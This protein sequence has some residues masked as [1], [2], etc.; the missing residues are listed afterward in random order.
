MLQFRDLLDLFDLLQNDI[1][2]CSATE[3]AAALVNMP[4]GKYANMKKEEKN[5]A[6]GVL[7][8]IILKQKTKQKLHQNETSNKTVLT[9]IPACMYYCGKVISNGLNMGWPS[10]VYSISRLLWNSKT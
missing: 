8:Q 7:Q 3:A 1:I 9:K 5:H 6:N 2:T 10:R 4:K